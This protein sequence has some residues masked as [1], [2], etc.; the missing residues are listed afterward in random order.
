MA[1]AARREVKS[2]YFFG[3]RL[4]DPFAV[5]L[6]LSLNTLETETAHGRLLGVFFFVA[7]SWPIS[8]IPTE[9]PENIATSF[10][11]VNLCYHRV[12]PNQKNLAV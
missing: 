6:A 2:S 10:T 4:G 8:A 11:V 5:S 1:A 9:M 3:V 7:V 12:K